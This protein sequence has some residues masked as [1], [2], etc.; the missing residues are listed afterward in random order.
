MARNPGSTIEWDGAY[1]FAERSPAM[2]AAKVKKLDE[3][4]EGIF[5]MLRRVAS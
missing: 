5:T 3:F 2:I 4:V 1:L